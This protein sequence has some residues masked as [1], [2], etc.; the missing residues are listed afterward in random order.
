MPRRELAANIKGMTET[1]M[2]LV[3]SGNRRLT[4][5]EA[6]DI[7]RFFGYQLPEDQDDPL[8]AL[9]SDRI[10]MLDEG[11]KRALALYLEALLGDAPDLP[12]AS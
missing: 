1:K 12:K 10:A 9:I 2:S 3:M 7:R 4:S 11:Q 6:D 8:S 5:E